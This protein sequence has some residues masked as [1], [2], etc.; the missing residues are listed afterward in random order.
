MSS[1]RRRPSFAG[2]LVAGGRAKSAAIFRIAGS[3][4]VVRLGYKWR[5]DIDRE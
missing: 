1:F 4:G 2:K 5:R 3:D